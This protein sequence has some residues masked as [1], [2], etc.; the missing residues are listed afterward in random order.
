MLNVD[1]ALFF[2]DTYDEFGDMDGFFSALNDIFINMINE[3]MQES[4]R[5]ILSYP[6]V[7][8]NYQG[9]VIQK[10]SFQRSRLGVTQPPNVL[11]L[12]TLAT[13][14]KI[15]MIQETSREKIPVNFAEDISKPCPIV[16]RSTLKSSPTT[17]EISHPERQLKISSFTTTPVNSGAT[18][19]L[20][21]AKATAAVLSMI[22]PPPLTLNQRQQLTVD[23]VD[24]RGISK[25]SHVRFAEVQTELRK[26]IIKVYLQILYSCYYY[27]F[28]I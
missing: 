16:Y 1:D 4:L 20:Q 18:A 25:K 28:I 12:S 17:E 14:N 6:N 15:Q 24:S 19:T 13:N 5:A 23:S 2:K 7:K 11:P 3:R 9:E 21:S 22:T 27:R 10:I 26:K 8:N